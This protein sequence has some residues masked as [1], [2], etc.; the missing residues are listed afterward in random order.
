MKIQFS[1]QNVLP[2]DQDKFLNG[3]YPGA[4][5]KILQV[6]NRLVKFGHSV[7]VKGMVEL[8]QTVNDVVY[9]KSFDVNSIIIYTYGPCESTG[10]IRIH[11]SCIAKNFPGHESHTHLIVCNSHWH[12]NVILNQNNINQIEVIPKGTNIP[13]CYN[14]NK[15]N[16][17]VVLSKNPRDDEIASQ[18]IERN[19]YK[20]ISSGDIE[21][22][23][24]DRNGRLNKKD[25]LNLLNS[26]KLLV[27]SSEY[28]E[29]F[30]S[31]VLDAAAYGCVPIV[32][33]RWGAGEIVYELGVRS[34]SIDE[35][36][37]WMYQLLDDSQKFQRFSCES[38]KQA[39]KYD[40][41]NIAVKW[42]ELLRRYE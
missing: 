36:E 28:A 5:D 32:D 15:K 4:A 21:Y 31:C 11:W 38:F 9:K 7:S 39:K 16:I 42:D 30:N 14:E 23:H 35:I 33:N 1:Y 24:I 17:V 18:F 20:K 40:W 10:R 34:N 29:T 8:E 6:A 26:A 27:F 22:Y 12:K 37:S 3:P 25:W 2:L 41:D 13:D 19:K